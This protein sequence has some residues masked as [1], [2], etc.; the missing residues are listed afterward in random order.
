MI[1]FNAKTLKII[2]IN[3]IEKHYFGIGL[4]TILPYSDDALE[5]ILRD[6]KLIEFLKAMPDYQGL[7]AT[8]PPCCSDLGNKGGYYLGLHKP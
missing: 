3:G 8:N 1:V 5:G 7:V 2:K 6:G 4:R